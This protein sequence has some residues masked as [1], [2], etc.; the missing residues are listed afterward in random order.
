MTKTSRKELIDMLTEMQNNIERLPQ[1]AMLEPISHYEHVA[2][3]ILLKAI[4]DADIQERPYE[5]EA[6]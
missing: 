3:I 5:K 6:L 4:F 2:L 1:H